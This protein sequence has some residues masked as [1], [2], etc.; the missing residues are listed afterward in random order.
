MYTTTKTSDLEAA[1]RGLLEKYAVDVSQPWRLASNALRSG[2]TQ[3]ENLVLANGRLLLE[4]EPKARVVPL[5]PWR[6]ERR[7]IELKS[8]VD[9]RTITPLLM[10]RFACLTDGVSKPLAA[11]LY[12]EFDL[13]EW[14]SGAPITSL[15]AVSNGLRCANIVARLASDALCSVE[16]STALPAGSPP[17]DR[18]ELIARRGVASDLA[19][20]T[21]IPQSSVYTFTAGGSEQHRDTDAELFGLNAEDASLA[22]AAFGVLSDPTQIPELQRRHDRLAGLV[23]NTF[24]SS[25]QG[26][27]IHVEGT[28]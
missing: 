2:D 17:V 9:T 20:D 5:F 28:R 13:I 1:V 24:D 23:K 4:N 10:C 18:H 8:M 6:E 25:R 7:F 21:Q 19:V 27:R 26:R 16:A 12:R 22:R 14:L 15:Y 11:V 3:D